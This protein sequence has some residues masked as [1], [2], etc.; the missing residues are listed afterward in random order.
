MSKKEIP[1]NDKY[2]LACRM[3]C[4][5]SNVLMEVEDFST[6]E[7]VNISIELSLEHGE[8]HLARMMSTQYSG[9]SH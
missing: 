7:L 8:N 3:I 2:S 5:L 6:P 1:L 4:D 9:E